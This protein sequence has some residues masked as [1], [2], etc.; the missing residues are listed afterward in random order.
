[1]TWALGSHR[2]VSS[3]Q[4]LRCILMH[5]LVHNITS[6]RR[7]I[8]KRDESV[9]TVPIVVR[10]INN[11]K[12]WRRTI[13][14][15]SCDVCVLYSP[16][17]DKVVKEEEDVGG[18]N[19]HPRCTCTFK[20]IFIHFPGQLIPSKH[21]LWLLCPDRTWRRPAIHTENDELFLWTCHY[22]HPFIITSA[23]VS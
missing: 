17:S 6:I 15:H 22:P 19:L 10:E 7:S 16:R 12:Q 3:V 8:G 13:C 5:W 1:M 21:Y 9:L 11:R 14:S 20:I 2:V 18:S 4:A 23:K